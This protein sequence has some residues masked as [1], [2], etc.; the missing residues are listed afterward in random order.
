MKLGRLFSI[1]YIFISIT[2]FFL[3]IAGMFL[4]SLFGG[5][6][7]HFPFNS[8]SGRWYSEAITNNDITTGAMNS[9]LIGLTSATLSVFFGLTS[10][11]L[12][13]RVRIKRPSIYILIVSLPILVPALLVGLGMLILFRQIGLYNNIYAI[14]IAHVCLCSPLAFVILYMSFSRLDK[15]VESAALNLGAPIYSV[16]M[17]ILFPQLKYSMLSSF[18][19]CFLLSINEFIV[20][21]F[22]GGFVKTLPTEIYGMLGGRINPAIYSIGVLFF[23]VTSGLLVFLQYSILKKQSLMRKL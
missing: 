17:R 23:I 20:T 21:W 7:P 14:I 18:L 13:H 5:E 12:L 9:L 22:L 1:A 6:V 3:P 8:Y 15:N 4:F 10:S 16:F 2:F 19:L 11:F